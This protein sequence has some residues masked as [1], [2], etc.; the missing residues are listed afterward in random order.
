MNGRVVRF[1]NGKWCK[2][3]PWPIFIVILDGVRPTKCIS[4]SGFKQDRMQSSKLVP[5]AV[6]HT[7]LVYVTT[8]S[9]AQ[10]FRER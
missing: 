2:E 5:D 4:P 8:L 6:E 9:V 7:C 10:T 3:L 1:I